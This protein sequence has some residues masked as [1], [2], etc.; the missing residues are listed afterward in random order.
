LLG[1][2]DHGWTV[3]VLGELPGPRSALLLARQERRESNARVYGRHF[4]VAVQEASGSFLRDVDGNVFIDFLTGAG[5]LSLGHC[6]PEL[7]AVAAE[8]LAR[9]GHGLDLPSPA[10]DAFVEAQLSMLPGRM[11]ARTK[12]HFCGPTGAN[13]VDAA[14]KLCKIATGRGDVIA[15]QGGFHGTTHLGMAVTGNVGTK[16]TVGNGVPG[17]HFFPFSQCDDCPLGLS[18]SSCA[19]N[20]VEYLERSLRDPNGGVPRPAAVLLELVQGE[21]GV[22]PA[23]LEFVQRVRAVT[24]ELDVPLVVDEVQTGCGRTGTWFAFEQ[25][26]IEPDVIVASKALS[27]IGQPIAVI[28]YDE[29]LDVWPPGA[30]TGTFRGNQVAFAAGARAVEIVR[31]DGVLGNVAA[32]GAQIA[33][34]LAVLRDRPGVRGVRGRGLM[35]GIELAD[36]ATGVRS[37][38]LAA[39][40]QARALRHGL[41]VELGG[42][43]DCVVRMLPPLNVPA[44]VVD[45]ACSILVEAVEHCLAASTR[46]PASNREL[47]PSAGR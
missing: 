24:A 47:L 21:G 35:W 39:L 45:Q 29:R 38:E 36:P 37:G 33:E 44:H 23:E 5:V 16:A 12:V 43:D 6:H 31:R 32:R 14:I 9:F 13:A 22:V 17:V 26:G 7:V 34:R 42:R 20:C 11:A 27:G 25:Y 15:F 3:R 40:V 8:Q 2:S 46:A 10:K 19:T 1:S 18:R 30:H 4:P 41:I 28:M